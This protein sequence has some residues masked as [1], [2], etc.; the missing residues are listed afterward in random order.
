MNIVP[1]TIKA[2]CTV[3]GVWGAAAF[4]NHTLHVRSL[5]WDA[6]NPISKFPII[7]VYH[8]SD[9]NLIV[10]ANIGWIGFV[11]VLTGMSPKIT[12]G[13]KVWLPRDGPVKTTR[14]GNPW[15][16]VLRDLLYEAHNIKESLKI[17][18]EAHRTCAIHIGLG[19]SEDQS[20]RMLEYS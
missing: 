15:T 17:L 9:P 1:E 11:G 10:H 6:G 20:F 2:A 14:Y 18:T 12:L 3:A 4:N 7:V 5:D 8:P 19:S 16:Y 13:E